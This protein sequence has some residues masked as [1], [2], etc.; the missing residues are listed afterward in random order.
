MRKIILFYLFTLNWIVACG[1]L[2]M[3]S[4]Y[5]KTNLQHTLIPSQKGQKILSPE[6]SFLIAGN[7]NCLESKTTPIIIIAVSNQ[8]KSGEIVSSQSLPKPGLYT[9]YVPEGNYILLIFADIDN[10]HFFESDELVGSYN[11]RQ[12]LYVGTYNAINGIIT[13]VNIDIS[14]SKPEQFELTSN[15]K[16]PNFNPSRRDKH[17]SGTIISLDDKIFSAENGRLGLYHPSIFLEKITYC[18]YR[19]EEYDENKIPI[20]FVHGAGGTPRDW[21][22][23]AEGIEKE[24]FQ[25]WF[26]YYPSGASIHKVAEGLY[27]IIDY[28]KNKFNNL[29][30][31][32]HSMGGLVVRDAVNRYMAARRDDYLKLFISISTPFGGSD[33]AGLGL[34]NLPIVVE[35][36]KDIASDSLFIKNLY[37]RQMPTHTEYY[38]FFGYKNMK[39]IKVGYNGDESLSLK[40]MLDNRAQKEAKKI[41][42]F[43]ETHTSILNSADVLLQYNK[44]LSSIK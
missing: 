8:F 32:A 41:F 1:Y 4:T 13:E 35:S 20:I 2:E 10:D 16:V 36:W 12:E 42:G 28:K 30:I 5:V 17:P 24:R 25:A 3:S 7:I 38:L 44:I 15:I 40:S 33:L 29:I 18:L 39:P 22:Y 34:A 31:T 6:N 19:L 26:F 9:L 11:N 27:K 14:F 43:N 21:K 23:F 37:R